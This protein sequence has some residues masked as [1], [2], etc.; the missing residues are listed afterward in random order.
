MIIGVKDSIVLLLDNN[1]V[2]RSELD[3]GMDIS[4]FKVSDSGLFLAVYTFYHTANIVYIYKINNEELSLQIFNKIVL[5][6]GED[7]YD[8]FVISPND[9]FLAT[10]SNGKIYVYYMQE[11]LET[12]P[13]IVLENNDDKYDDI[14]NF[15]PDSNVLATISELSCGKYI[16]RLF[17]YIIF[18]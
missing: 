13:V 18:S 1:G 14:L 10:I 3:T 12:F 5:G 11:E 9:K 6:E 15:S 16:Y 2:I 17:Y 7:V 4:C 8:N